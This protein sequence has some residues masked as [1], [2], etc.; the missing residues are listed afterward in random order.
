MD[1]GELV[2][3]FVPTGH[4]EFRAIVDEC[5]AVGLDVELRRLRVDRGTGVSRTAA[6]A[7]SSR[8]TSPG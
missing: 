7:T 8:S 6:A 4:E 3:S 5:E 2:V 1:D